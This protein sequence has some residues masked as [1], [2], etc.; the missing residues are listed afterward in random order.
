MRVGVMSSTRMESA[1]RSGTLTVNVM[2]F[3]RLSIGPV[4][5]VVSNGITRATLRR[6]T[7]RSASAR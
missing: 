6:N 5:C 4:S 1:P 7:S 3:F 2:F